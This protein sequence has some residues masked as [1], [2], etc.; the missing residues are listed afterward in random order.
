[1]KI[2]QKLEEWLKTAADQDAINITI[3]LKLPDFE[4]KTKKE[5]YSS[6]L[7]F[8]KA[9]TEEI[10]TL[11]QQALVPHFEK[12]QNIGFVYCSSVYFS[13]QRNTKEEILKLLPLDIGSVNIEIP[14]NCLC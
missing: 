5:D 7:E 14:E 9:L 10:K 11:R 6:I 2:N 3:F 1:M 12:M 8:R 4:Y 13:V